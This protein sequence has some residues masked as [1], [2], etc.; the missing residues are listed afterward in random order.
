MADIDLSEIIERNGYMQRSRRSRAGQV[1]EAHN[2]KEDP[3]AA[4]I[5]YGESPVLY[6]L[7][8]LPTSRSLDFLAFGTF[9]KKRGLFKVKTKD[10]LEANGSDEQAHFV[11]SVRR[12]I[13]PYFNN[14]PGNSTVVL[15]C[16][17]KDYKAIQE[18]ALTG[19]FGYLR[20]LT[21]TLDGLFCKYSELLPARVAKIEW[22]YKIK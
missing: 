13:D 3:D 1:F 20:D 10:L 9:P 15:V 4:G 17:E 8:N 19:E 21:D 18:I 16:G 14:R 22:D 2:L 5:N 12:V 7:R 6:V 11:A